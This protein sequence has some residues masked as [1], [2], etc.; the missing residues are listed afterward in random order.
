MTK[1]RIPNNLRKQVRERALGYRKYCLCPESH[2]T[3]GH[4]LEHIF[5]EEL[6]GLSSEDNLDLACQ[7]C[8]NIKYNKTEALDPVNREL[9]P[10]FHPRRDQWHEHFTWG[11]DGLTLTGITPTGR[12][13][14]EALRLNRRGVLN[15]R[16]LLLQDGK[17]PPEHRNS[18]IPERKRDETT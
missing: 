8:N 1:Q 12:A 18:V 7:G 17:H 13:T 16:R 2:A 5:P 4:S 3:Q 15:L 11:E 14:V 6:G 10:L 9:A